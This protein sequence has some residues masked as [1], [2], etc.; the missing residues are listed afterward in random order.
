MLKITYLSQ[1]L[2]D[3]TF[4]GKVASRDLDECARHQTHDQS[5]EKR[6]P[7]FPACMEICHERWLVDARSQWINEIKE[8]RDDK[9]NRVPGRN[10]L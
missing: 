2:D 4:H 5:E 1:T 6:V 3:S 10:S 7:L 8:E 9:L